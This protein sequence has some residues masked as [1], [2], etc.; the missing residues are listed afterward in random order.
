MP[1]QVEDVTA[2]EAA[3]AAAAAAPAAPRRT[4]I[5]TLSGSRGPAAPP[6]RVPP[7]RRYE[8]N[9]EFMQD[10]KR[11]IPPVELRELDLSTG[12]PRPRPVDIVLGDLR[13]TPYPAE[14][15]ARQQAEGA[16]APRPAAA[17]S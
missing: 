11:G 5:A 14:A 16:A 7:L 9:A 13:P 10:L 15:A 6:P 4:G 12:T 3:A 17:P 1:S 8:D 2:E